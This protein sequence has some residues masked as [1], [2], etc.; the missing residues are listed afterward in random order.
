MDVSRGQWGQQ[1]VDVYDSVVGVWE[2]L[3]GQN[4]L[5]LREE[6]SCKVNAGNGT[7][8]IGN[9]RIAF[10]LDSRDDEIIYRYFL[11]DA[12]DRLSLKYNS[13]NPFVDYIRIS[14]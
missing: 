1:G 10:K 8:T 3:N 7:Y 9:G 4:S 2:S 6:L 13:D 14:G 12:G 5:V 11:S